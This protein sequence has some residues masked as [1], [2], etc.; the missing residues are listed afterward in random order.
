MKTGKLRFRLIACCSLLAVLFSACSESKKTLK[1]IFLPPSVGIDTNIPKYLHNVSQIK[2]WERMSQ[3]NRATNFSWWDSAG[4]VREMYDY[5]DKIVVLTFFGTWSQPA[6]TQLA[7]IDTVIRS[8]DTNVMIIA[9]S[10]R[11]GVFN[12]KAVLRIDSFVHAQNIKYQVL[13]GS[14]D[15]GFTYGGV[16]AVPTTFVINR[17]R[18]IVG[19]FEGFAS[20]EMLMEA[21]KKAEATP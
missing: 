6:L 10:M 13:I 15:F 16:D 20:S 21:I 2:V 5:Y 19:T 11:E 3:A 7:T 17:K 8:G 14:R 12:G 18:K 4:N 9:A 1:D